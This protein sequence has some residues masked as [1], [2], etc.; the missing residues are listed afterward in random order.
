MAN[1]KAVIIEQPDLVVQIIFER[2]LWLMQIPEPQSFNKMSMSERTLEEGLMMMSL[3]VV[4]SLWNFT[5]VSLIVILKR[6]VITGT[7]DIP[8][9]NRK[10]TVT[11]ILKSD[12]NFLSIA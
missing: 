10:C 6:Q 3:V 2:N 7:P 8:F 9:C 5:V 1:S 11:E 4:Q 12:G